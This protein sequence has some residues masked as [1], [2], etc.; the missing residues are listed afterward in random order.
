MASGTFRK[1]IEFAYG[2][3]NRPWFT[4]SKFVVWNRGCAVL[5]HWAAQLYRTRDGEARLSQA[6]KN[7]GDC[8]SDQ[9]RICWFVNFGFS[10]RSLRLR[11][12]YFRLKCLRDVRKG[13]RLP[14]LSIVDDFIGE[15]SLERRCGGLSLIE[16]SL[17]PFPRR[18]QLV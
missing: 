12:D 14:L 7:V 11:C 2:L 10:R 16:A 13:S 5:L 3:F 17:H 6:A 15:R 1:Q 8:R 4:D 9:T 18:L